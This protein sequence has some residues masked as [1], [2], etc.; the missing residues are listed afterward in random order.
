MVLILLLLR[1]AEYLRHLTMLSIRRELQGRYRSEYSDLEQGIQSFVTQQAP[2]KALH[3]S[4]AVIPEAPVAPTLQETTLVRDVNV[5]K[6]YVSSVMLGGKDCQFGKFE[7]RDAGILIFLTSLTQGKGYR[8]DQVTGYIRFMEHE[9]NDDKANGELKIL[10]HPCPTSA[11]HGEPRPERVTR[12]FLAYPKVEALG[13]G[14]ELGGMEQTC[15]TDV[16]RSWHYSCTWR[17]DEHGKLTV[18]Q[19]NWQADEGD[20]QVQHA[21]P[22][23]SGV[24]VGPLRQPFWVGCRIQPLLSRSSPFKWLKRF[25][26][27][28]SEEENRH[29][30]TKI[31][32]SLTDTDLGTVVDELDVRINQL[33][34]SNQKSK[35]EQSSLREISLSKLR[36]GQIPSDPSR[37]TLTR[38]VN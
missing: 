31:L 24:V 10:K 13:I 11:I 16:V 1:T 19:C 25:M 20:P 29:I 36:T 32:P 6:V 27:H 12:K 26:G 22:L 3:D 8:L 5:D 28:P 34:R 15:E 21:G 17:G 30:F 23:Y 7:G 38:D 14:G 37:I 2:A 4:P 33:I 18:T 35:Q 9:P